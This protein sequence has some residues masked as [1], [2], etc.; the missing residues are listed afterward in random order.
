MIKYHGTPLTPKSVFNQALLNRD[1]LIPFTRKDDLK[2][3]FKICR[4]I[5]IDNGAFTVWRKGIDIDWNDY[6]NWIDG[7]YDDITNFFIPDVIDGTEEENNQLVANYLKKRL[8]NNF[9]KDK[10]GIP[11]WHIDESLHRL[12]M[13]MD[14]FDYIAIGSAGEFRKLDTEKWHK[15][16]NDAMAIICDKNGVPKVKIHMLRCLNPKIFTQY[17]FY[18]GDS[19]SLAQNHNIY[20]TFTNGKS[21]N[22]G[23]KI[24]LNRLERYNSPKSF[25]FKKYHEQMEMF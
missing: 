19:T 7:I 4:R 11:V 18:S 13:M 17:P 6:Y 15:R 21:D 20:N 23:W 9:D 8:F 5:I 16:M 2:K 24:I 14:S 3:A 12:S 25:S 1:C 10:K 22:N